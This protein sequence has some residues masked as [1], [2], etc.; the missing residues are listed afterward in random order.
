MNLEQLLAQLECAALCGCKR[1]AKL[2]DMIQR[3]ITP[4]DNVT[5]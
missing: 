4:I 5:V 1:S 2:F 3:Y